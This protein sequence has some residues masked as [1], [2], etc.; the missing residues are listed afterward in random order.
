MSGLDPN[1]I[2]RTLQDKVQ[3]LQELVRKLGLTY[4]EKKTELVMFTRRKKIP[5]LTPFKMGDTIVP[6]SAEA[7]YLGITLDEGLTYSSHIKQKVTATKKCI[8]ALNSLVR[9]RWG[10]NPKLMRLAYTSVARSKLTY[11]GHVWQ[12]KKGQDAQVTRC[13]RLGLLTLAPT[14]PSTPTLGL[15]AIWGIQPIDLFLQEAALKTYVHIK[16][17]VNPTLH[18]KDCHLMKLK[19]LS[20]VN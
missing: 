6:I 1:I 10:P 5:K 7:K 18:D 17:K 15:Q 12:H 2:I 3:K 19:K 14:Q 9:K 16:D 13:Q 4:N 8:M 11:G 20:A